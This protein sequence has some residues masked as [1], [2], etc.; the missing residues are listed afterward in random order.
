MARALLEDLTGR[1]LD[2]KRPRLFV[3]DGAFRC[4]GRSPNRGTHFPRRLVP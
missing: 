1:G 2:S 4:H 3:L